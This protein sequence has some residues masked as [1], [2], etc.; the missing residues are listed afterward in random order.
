MKNLSPEPRD[1]MKT[2]NKLSGVGMV[3]S[4][5]AYGEGA[6]RVLPGGFGGWGAEGNFGGLGLRVQDWGPPRLVFRV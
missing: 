2:F 3:P 5:Q 1:S 6:A 4:S